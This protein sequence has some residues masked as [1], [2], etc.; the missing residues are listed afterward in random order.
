MNRVAH[1][2][3]VVQMVGSSSFSD[4]E[5][6]QASNRARRSAFHYLLLLPATAGGPVIKP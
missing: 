6:S 3:R 4:A 2:L 1:P 5:E